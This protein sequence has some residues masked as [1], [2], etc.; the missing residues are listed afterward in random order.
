MG[1]GRVMILERHEGAFPRKI[2]VDFFLAP[3]SPIGKMGRP[4]SVWG[5]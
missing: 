1:P 3:I 5:P 4:G 2:K